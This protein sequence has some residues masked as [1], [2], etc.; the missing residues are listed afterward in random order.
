MRASDFRVLAKRRHKFLLFAFC[1]TEA[2]SEDAE[3]PKRED[4][5]HV[6]AKPLLD[7]VG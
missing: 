2:V 4:L 6:S 5:S 3:V 1:P 7:G